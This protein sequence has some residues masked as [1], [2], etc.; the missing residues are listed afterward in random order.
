VGAID[1]Q[2]AAVGTPDDVACSKEDLAA[3]PVAEASHLLESATSASRREASHR[4]GP[5]ATEG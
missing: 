2:I 1:L 5:A 3:I 4:Q